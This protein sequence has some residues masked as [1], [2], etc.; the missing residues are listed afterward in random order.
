MRITPLTFL[1]DFD[2]LEPQFSTT[3]NAALDCDWRF[4]GVKK[5]E[6]KL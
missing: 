1:Q 6:K 3:L 2:S 4:I 5:E